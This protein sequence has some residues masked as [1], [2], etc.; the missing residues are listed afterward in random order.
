MMVIHI[1]RV[2]VGQSVFVRE[3]FIFLVEVHS[4]AGPRRVCVSHHF[5][6]HLGKVGRKARGL[7]RDRTQGFGAGGRIDMGT[8][9]RRALRRVN[10]G[11]W[12]GTER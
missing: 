7:R 9:M 5:L 4:V 1:N 3:R 12:T 8:R 2:E 6:L 11:R 10:D